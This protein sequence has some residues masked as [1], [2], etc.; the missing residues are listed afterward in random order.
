VLWR[1][2]SSVQLELGAD[3]VVVEGIDPATVRALVRRARPTPAA[4]AD[5]PVLVRAFESGSLR[6]LVEAGYVWPA[7]RNSAAFPAPPTPRLA[8]DVTSLAAR[9]GRIAAGIVQARRHRSVAVIGNGRVATLVASVLG[10]S[11]IGR[12]HF[13]DSGDV[14]LHQTMPGGL[15]PLA[16]GL[17]F[18]AAAA[19]ELRRAAPD[20][21][22]AAQ[23]MGIVPDLT[24]LALDGPIDSERRDALHARG[25]A[26][27]SVRLGASSGVVGP[28]VV[29]GRTG[30]L[31][32]ADLHRRDRDPAWHALAVQL[33]VAPYRGTPSDVGAA[34]VVAGVTALQ[35]LAFLDGE[36]TATVDGTIELHLPDWRLRRRSWS[37]HPDC[38]C[39]A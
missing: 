33:T 36:P 37:M 25:C 22:T 11:G 27:L 35:A 3:G 34:T 31:R 28:L 13:A 4:D 32:C 12:V 7:A 6:A 20:V 24:V 30:C 8:A 5:A 14:H 9:H 21:D 17:R 16:E 38:G 29:P 19:D 1:D 23:P 18:A 26:H 10:A 2:V 39:G 15:P